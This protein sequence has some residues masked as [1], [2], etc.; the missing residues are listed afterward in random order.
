AL[1]AA[2][3]GV[4]VLRERRTPTPLIRLGILRSSTLVRGNLGA[5]AIAG[6]V[7]FQFVATL[8]MQQLRGWSSLETGLAIF[9]AGLLVAV[10]SPRVGGLVGR[11]GVTRLAVAGLT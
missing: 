1:V 9:P 7:G 3:L 5:M 6:W 2:I 11:F 10:L 8:Y 4:F